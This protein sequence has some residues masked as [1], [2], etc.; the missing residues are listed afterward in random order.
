MPLAGVRGAAAMP[1]MGDVVRTNFAA[2][3]GGQEGSR[4]GFG[5]GPAQGGQPGGRGIAGPGQS[6]GSPLVRR[7]TQ[8]STMS[9]T[10]NGGAQ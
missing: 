6:P 8:G 1:D 4:P 3:L 2:M 10:F 9:Q 7:P 5:P